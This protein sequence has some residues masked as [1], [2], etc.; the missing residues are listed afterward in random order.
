MALDS[1][2][3]DAS[4]PS[5]SL[6]ASAGVGALAYELKFLLTE[7]LAAAVERSLAPALTPDPHGEA[8]LS[9]AYRTL[10]VYCDNERWEVLTR[11]G[12]GATTKLRVRQY[13]E[14]GPIFLER[15]QTQNTQ[16]IKKRV[17]V[18]QLDANSHGAEEDWFW[19][20]ATDRGLAP[21]CAVQYER[22]AFTGGDGHGWRLTFDRN[23]RCTKANG[24]S[25]GVAPSAPVLPDLVLCEMK[26][27]DVLPSIFKRTLEQHSIAPVSVSKYRRSARVLGLG[28]GAGPDA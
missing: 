16:V 9:G 5:P 4:T 10:S 18:A 22:R 8:A 6:R 11:S 24:W 21:V 12:A 19:S 13:G 28:D 2:G 1:R 26:F 27:L 20:E 3:S 15:K 25:L 17:A 14:R 7:E 23:I